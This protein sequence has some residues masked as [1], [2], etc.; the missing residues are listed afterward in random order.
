MPIA[1]APYAQSLSDL[2]LK[3]GSEGLP[4]DARDFQNPTE[5]KYPS[6]K[7]A[8]SPGLFG[9]SYTIIAV[10]AIVAVVFYISK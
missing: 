5:N 9:N 8:E 4:P 7:P 3:G 2:P 1:E 10:I 6:K